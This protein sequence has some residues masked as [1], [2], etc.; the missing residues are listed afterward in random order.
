MHLGAYLFVQ[1]KYWKYLQPFEKGDLIG[2]KPKT[3]RAPFRHH[4][5]NHNMSE[6]NRAER[7]SR[8]M[9]PHVTDIFFLGGVPKK[10]IASTGIRNPSLN[11]WAHPR[12]Q[13]EELRRTEWAE[14][15]EVAESGGLRFRAGCR[16]V[17]VFQLREDTWG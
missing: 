3:D 6:D 14:S 7:C 8:F 17:E 13:D 12:G 15:A 4:A 1:I 9:L 16:H 10:E 2:L 11:A 5:E